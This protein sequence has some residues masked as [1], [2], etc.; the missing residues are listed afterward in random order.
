MAAQTEQPS[1][2]PQPSTEELR[3]ALVRCPLLPVVMV[4]ERTDGAA[5][6]AALAAG[7]LTAAEVVLRTP[8]AL[9][10]VAEMAGTPGLLVGAGT[11]VEPDQVD[12]VADAGARFVVSPGHD[13]DVVAR[14]RSRGIP[15]VPGT[16]T[17]TEVQLARRSGLRVLKVFPAGAVGGTA[18]LAGLAG[19]FPDVAFVP[20]GGIGERDL[21]DYLAVPAVAAVGGS[22]CAP[23][24]LVARVT[25]G[26]SDD[27][28][29][30]AAALSALVAASVAAARRARP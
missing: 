15:A 4:G 8:S 10:V 24:S 16:S 11:V 7:G 25:G 12:A 30:A 22:W 21:A 3:A 23:A 6:G 5:L 20:T 27:S 9:R 2:P 19:P 13:P 17:A 14:A 29:A 26:G 1:Q 18:L 28:S